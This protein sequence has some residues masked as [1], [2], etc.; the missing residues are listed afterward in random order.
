M[1]SLLLD[2]TLI[3]EKL[4]GLAAVTKA[5]AVPVFGFLIP[6]TILQ[7]NLQ[8]IEAKQRPSYSGLLMRVIVVVL[9]LL[10]YNRLFYFMLKLSQVMSFAILSEQQWG[11]FLVTGFKAKG[12]SPL[13]VLVK[14]VSSV[15]GLILFLTTLLTL[16]VREVVVMLQACFLSLLYAF[17]PLALACAVN[18]GSSK[19][20]KS[21]FAT[22]LQV[23]FWTFFMRLALRVW[24]TLAP[25]AQGVGSMADD[26][27]GILAVNLTFFFLILNTPRI[28]ALLLSGDNL[29]SFGTFAMAAVQTAIVARNL[30]MAGG[31][32]GQARLAAAAYVKAAPDESEKGRRRW[33]AGFVNRP[34]ATTATEAYGRLFG[35]P[36]AKPKPGK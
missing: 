11:Q 20:A 31:L 30:Q 18:E 8:A 13:E 22:T 35:F 21:W 7:M 1:N 17:G 4:G 16:L 33:W 23:A 5:I 10:S 25:M 29:A 3:P 34:V 2:V 15:Q 14:G 27:V 9:C 24:L 28:S 6:A 26:Y 12:T 36:P 32:S 19:I